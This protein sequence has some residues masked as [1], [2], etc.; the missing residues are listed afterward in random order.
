MG[1]FESRGGMRFVLPVK[2]E[3]LLEDAR[4]IVSKTPNDQDRQVFI[5]LRHSAN[6]QEKYNDKKKDEAETG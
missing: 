2:S 3:S 5:D 6:L 4:V 1:M